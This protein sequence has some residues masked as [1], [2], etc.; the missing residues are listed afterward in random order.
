MSG[1]S[2][3]DMFDI[4]A[5]NTGRNQSQNSRS[6]PITREKSISV[7]K[8][9]KQSDPPNKTQITLKEM[10]DKVGSADELGDSDTLL[11]SFM[12]LFGTVGVDSSAEESKPTMQKEKSASVSGAKN[13]SSELQTIVFNHSLERSLQTVSFNAVGAAISQPLTLKYTSAHSHVKT[14]PA[15]LD[16]VSFQDLQVDL[17]YI[18]IVSFLR[19][20]HEVLLTVL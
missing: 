18:L 5:R 8:E 16:F 15:L 17:D 19:C 2:A 3:L 14:V 7:N 4:P 10:L 6:L 9:I 1:K 20:L 12:S 11:D 13:V